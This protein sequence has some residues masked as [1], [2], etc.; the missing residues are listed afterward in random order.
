VQLD[1]DELADSGV[2]LSETALKLGN[3]RTM[4]VEKG[5][6]SNSIRL[7]GKIAPNDEAISSQTSHIGGR[8]E[9]LNVNFEGEYVRRGQVIA[10]VYSP[11]LV[12]AEKE[13]FVAQRMKDSQP[14]LFMAAK[15]KLKNWKLT[16]KQIEN[17]LA[18]GK[19]KDQFPIL[20]DVSGVVIKKNVNPGDHIQ[21]GE[22]LYEIAD[23]TDLWVELEVHEADIAQISKGNKVHYTVDAFS[24]K[25]Y[26]GTIDFIDPVIDPV[27]RVAMARLTLKNTDR[28]LK[29]GMLVTATVKYSE[30]TEESIV[31]PATAVLWTGERS[32]VYVGK[33]ASSGKVFNLRIVTLGAKT[34]QGYI[35]TEGLEVGEEIVTNGTFTVDAAAQLAGE[36]S[37][38]NQSGSKGDVFKRENI[39]VSVNRQT[40]PQTIYEFSEI[41][42]ATEDFKEQL[43]KAFEAYQPV[44]NALIETSAPETL[45]NL[46]GYI[47][48]IK[49]IESDDLKSEERQIWE[50]DREV[51]LSNAEKILAS[52]DIES[53]RKWFSPLSDQFYHTLKKFDLKGIGYRQ[54]CPMAFDNEGAFWLR[55]SDEVLNPY[56]GDE[57]LTCGNVE[58]E[59]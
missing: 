47:S 10:Y 18:S 54:Y 36:P 28:A 4:I 8:I 41:L 7:I 9:K 55:D 38:M 58:E 32:V 40:Q 12:N 39:A 34:E 16:D 59:L 49:A 11:E 43:R 48:A 37:M 2:Q 21:Q 35:I 42:E 30:Q 3:V 51:I 27:T 44:K 50:R 56:F 22:S 53:M 19:P 5:K 31:I 45:K 26:E 14:E 6:G 52:G 13:L 20:S 23:L 57:M 17:I 33:T 29:P 15:E 1:Q 25:K 24:D 46:P